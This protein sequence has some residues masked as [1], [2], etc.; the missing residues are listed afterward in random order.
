MRLLGCVGI[1]LSWLSS[2]PCQTHSKPFTAL[3]MLPV[4]AVHVYPAVCGREA[5]V[6][7]SEHT[8]RRLSEKSASTYS[9]S[10]DFM[11]ARHGR[12][13]FAKCVERVVLPTPATRT[14]VEPVV[15]DDVASLQ[16][17]IV[18][19][20]AYASSVL[21]RAPPKIYVCEIGRGPE[22]YVI[23]TSHYPFPP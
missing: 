21:M 11:Q 15:W 3:R 7:S 14:T 16:R 12:L 6:L 13:P 19:D 22:R 17:L 10:I 9:H 18:S 8:Q 1:K 20:R 2:N 5:S 4:S 23:R